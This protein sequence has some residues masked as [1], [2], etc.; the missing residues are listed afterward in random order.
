LQ[1]G[2]E[3]CPQVGNNL[4]TIPG[5]RA[6]SFRSDCSPMEG[7]SGPADLALLRGRVGEAALG[8]IVQVSLPDGSAAALPES[9][10]G[11]A[12]VS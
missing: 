9:P 8:G 5:P 11:A 7:T 3:Y 12:T 2:V 4:W 6:D 1:K 10:A